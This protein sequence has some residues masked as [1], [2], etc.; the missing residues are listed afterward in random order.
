MARA[1]KKTTRKGAA[2]K[3]TRK[4]TA[5]RGRPAAKKAA[6]KKRKSSC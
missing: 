6:T 3:S 1:T 2:K 5:K 4:A